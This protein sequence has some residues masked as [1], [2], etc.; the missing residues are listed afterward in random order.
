MLIALVLIPLVLVSTGA[1]ISGADKTISIVRCNHNF[2]R[3]Q[4]L[5]PAEKNSTDLYA[6]SFFIP[7]QWMHFIILRKL[8]TPLPALVGNNRV[9][10]WLG[11]LVCYY[12]PGRFLVGNN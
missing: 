2:L 10:S 5:A 3:A 12:L 11:M 4:E 9:Y 7:E 6:M 8:P 1:D